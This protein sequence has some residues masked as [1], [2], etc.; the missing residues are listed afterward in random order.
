MPKGIKGE[1]PLPEGVL[2]LLMTGEVPTD[3]DFHDL[4]KELRHRAELTPDLINFITK[5]PKD[6]PPITQLYQAVL[7]LQK[8][9]LFA[10]AYRRGVHKSQYWDTLYEDALNLVAKVPEIAAIIYRHTYKV[11]SLGALAFDS[12]HLFIG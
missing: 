3:T 8:D 1:E 7:Y 2:Y 5:L 12:H 6:T 4:Q 10:D 9:S 11:R